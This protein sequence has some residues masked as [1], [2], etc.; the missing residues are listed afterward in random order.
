ML[1]TKK[2]ETMKIT[3]IV[4][5]AIFFSI[6]IQSQKTYDKDLQDTINWTR[7]IYEKN[8]AVAPN[9]S[10]YK[11]TLWISYPS[12]GVAYDGFGIPLK[13][14]EFNFLNN[15]IKVLCLGTDSTNKLKCIV[16][17]IVYMNDRGSRNYPFEDNS[18]IPLSEK[19][20]KDN[21]GICFCN[22]LN[23]ISRRLREDID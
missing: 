17:K 16:R 19:F 23:Y 13:A 7:E 14:V 15:E 10:I 9:L 11:D 4:V 21:Q 6:N 20:N 22:T 2:H 5:F 18:I 8:T 12:N 1:K 3:L